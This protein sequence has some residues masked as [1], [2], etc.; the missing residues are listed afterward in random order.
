MSRRWGCL[1]PIAS[2]IIGRNGFAVHC[3]GEE[4]GKPPSKKARKSLYDSGQNAIKFSSEARPGLDA[5][6]QRKMERFD[7]V[8]LHKNGGSSQAACQST[9]KVQA[10]SGCTGTAGFELVLHSLLGK[11]KVSCL[12]ASECWPAA[13]LFAFTRAS[14]DHIFLDIDAAA[15]PGKLA[16]CAAHGLRLCK[17][18]VQEQD[19][20]SAG[21]SCKPYSIQNIH[22]FKRNPIQDPGADPDVDTYFAVFKHIQ[23]HRPKVSILENNKGLSMGEDPPMDF[24]MNDPQWGLT[25]LTDMTTAY[26][27]VR[28]TDANLPTARPRYI[29]FIVRSDIGRASDMASCCCNKHT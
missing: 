29:F 19:L 6:F 27:L 1:I 28:G 2:S 7:W 13:G 8:V 22:R 4:N 25:H 5:Y 15:H 12:F 11:D 17:V 18:P 23:N 21:F 20:Y 9:D 14:P 16:P 3:A 26:C 10:A 24:I